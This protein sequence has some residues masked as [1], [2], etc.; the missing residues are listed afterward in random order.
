MLPERF[1]GEF[2][3]VGCYTNLSSFITAAAHFRNHHLIAIDHET[4]AIDSFSKLMITGV[5]LV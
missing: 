1:R 3:T 5:T 2:V 4:A